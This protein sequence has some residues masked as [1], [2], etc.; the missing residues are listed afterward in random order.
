MKKLIVISGINLYTGG[1]LSIYL[2]FLTSVVQKHYDKKYNIVA[3]VH[4]KELFEN[5][6]ESRI[7]FVELPA[8]RRS[9]SNRLYYEYVWF[10][11]YSKA[12]NVY[13]WLSLHDI[14]PNV[15]AE[16]R[17][18]YCHSPLP[19]LNLTHEIV[20]NYPK[21]ALMKYLYRYV[22]AINIKKND[23]VIV[24]Q[25][26][27]RQQF[28]KLFGL[29][30]RSVAVCKPL[31]DNEAIRNSE[32]NNNE[33]F[34]FI[35]AAYPRFFK[36]Y[37]IIARAAALL[38]KQN[39]NF[40]IIFTIDGSENKYSE[41]VY[42]CYRNIPNI[43]WKGLLSREEVFELYGKADALIFPSL[44]ETWGLPISE[45]KA[46]GKLML[47]A[48]LPYAYETVQPYEKVAFF[49]PNDEQELFK[50]MKDAVDGSLKNVK[51]EKY[52]YDEPFYS[53][54]NEF[55]EKRF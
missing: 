13:I 45:F 46:T 47:L 36:N 5:F 37:E 12:K 8:S 35:Y 7:R 25:D 39:S 33:P 42:K 10:Y 24:Q 43:D 6:K 40:K 34:V 22:Y 9:Y 16:K 21:A 17:M 52:E 20:K 26:W 19:F 41:K 23:C 38:N 28:N 18:V 11:K 32:K 27:M 50:V 54:W 48:D 2:D 51:I 3:F 30:K 4:K 49:N 14:T 15:I 44:L 1:P 29:K 55:L 53:D 31:M